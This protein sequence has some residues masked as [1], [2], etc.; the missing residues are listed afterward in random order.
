[1]RFTIKTVLG[2]TAL[3]TALPTK[4]T[5]AGN[6]TTNE[7]VF[8]Q[9]TEFTS[10]SSIEEFSRELVALLFAAAEQNVPTETLAHLAP[11]IS[12]EKY[13][14]LLSPIYKDKLSNYNK[15]FEVDGIESSKIRWLV[16]AK[17]RQ[18][19]DPV[20]LYLHGG[21]YAFGMLPTFPVAL[22]RTYELTENDRLSILMLDYTISIAPNGQYP[23]Q[24][25]ESAKSFN[26]LAETSSNI[27]IGGDS[28]GGHLSLGMLRSIQ[29]P[30]ESVPELAFKPNGTI[31]ISPW[32]NLYPEQEGWY[33]K[34]FKK[35]ILTAKGLRGFTELFVED[36]SQYTAAALN[37]YVDYDVDWSDI[38]PPTDHV[39]TSFGE[40]EVLRGDINQWAEIAGATDTLFYDE[41]F[42]HDSPCI[43]P[44]FSNVVPAIAEFFKRNLD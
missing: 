30:V 19:E 17:D 41:G 25:I 2:L 35:D 36:P 33:V 16:E 20:L 32:V 5:K 26:K 18:P 10:T 11:Q 42:Y 12:T 3:A 28:A 21:G 37:P 1:M 27:Y 40:F 9:S 7:L 13:L 23:T 43:Y 34:N 6:G 15:P 14:D 4:N 29:Y 39:F 44:T 22:A 38:L 24:L 8:P 31:L